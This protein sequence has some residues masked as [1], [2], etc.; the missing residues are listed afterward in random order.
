LRD[1]DELLLASSGE[2]LRGLLNSYGGFI[3]LVM[4]DLGLRGNEDGLTLS[5][6]LRDRTVQDHQAV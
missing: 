3:D 4:V 6:S 5:A 1:R 2:E